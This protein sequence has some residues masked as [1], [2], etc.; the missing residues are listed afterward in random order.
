MYNNEFYR[1]QFI[2]NGINWV[3][4][5]EG[6]KA[7]QL[8]PNSNVIL[9]DSENDG[10]FYIKVSDNVGICNLRVFKYEEVADYNKPAVPIDTSQFVTK[11]ELE[12][13][14]KG[15]KVDKDGKQSV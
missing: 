10:F 15:L 5:L 7:Y 3:Q 4:G 13:I 12:E 2:Q 14:L 9:M 11:T 8:M 1:P 6:A